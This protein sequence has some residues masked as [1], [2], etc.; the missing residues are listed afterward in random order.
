MWWEL[1]WIG[2]KIDEKG[3]PKDIMWKK[4]I[5]YKN[6]NCIKDVHFKGVNTI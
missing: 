1:P 2:I 3:S 6:E 5:H 4:E